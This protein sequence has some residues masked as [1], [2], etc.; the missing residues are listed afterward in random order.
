MKIIDVEQNSLDWLIARA[1]VVTAS[2]MDALV[3]PKW[4][5]RESKGVETYLTQKLA[6]K[7]LGGPLPGFMDVDVE[8]GKILEE[9]AIPAYEFDF[10][11]LITR[12]GFVTTDDGLFGCSP[13]G[14][15]G[16]DGGIEIK[17]PR[18]DS[19]I[20]YLLADEV[21][22]QYLA[23]VHFSMFVTG[24]PWWKFMSYRPKMPMLVKLVERDEK[25]I[26]VLEEATGD[27]KEK[28]NAAWARLVEMN[29]GKEP[30]RRPVGVSAHAP[31]HESEFAHDVTP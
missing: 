27:F 23:Q 19:H 15:I 18:L 7:W 30:V 17:C 26:E 3:S 2:E 21:P 28:M 1:G 16:S 29:G 25:I 12:V 8:I 31:A 5:V 9:K 24:R 13:D 4:K 11:E 14:L 20:K 22:D 6:E 10:S